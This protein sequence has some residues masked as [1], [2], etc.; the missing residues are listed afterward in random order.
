[1]S[2]QPDDNSDSSKSLLPPGV[3][4]VVVASHRRSGTHLMMDLLRRHF[5]ACRPPFRFGVNPHRYLYFV[6]DR[7]RPTHPHHVGVDACLRVMRSTPMPALKTHATPQFPDLPKPFRDF[8]SE[9]LQRGVVIYCVRDVRAV[10]ASLHAFESV[11]DPG[12]RVSLS[13]YIRQEV[14]GRIRP[15]IWADHVRTWIDYVPSLKVLYFEDVITHP[16]AT[17]N[18]LAEWL[19]ESP[20]VVEPVLPPKLKY[21][22]VLWLAR[23]TGVPESTNVIGRKGGIKPQNWRTEYTDD[24]LAVLEKHAGDEMRR[25]GYL[26][27]RDWTVTAESRSFGV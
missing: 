17:V 18:Q 16:R 22:Q 20:R 7:L 23:M 3:T 15:R 26:R 12:A 14:D 2:V 1:M 19:G 9:A 24:D 13:D 4:P 6:L 8:C 5:D 21:R 10:L 25:L 11:Y 27:G